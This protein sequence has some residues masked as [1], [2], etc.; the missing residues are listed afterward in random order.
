[1]GKFM[2]CLAIRRRF[3]NRV[4]K[5]CA[6]EPESRSTRHSCGL[7]SRS[8]KCTTA[9]INSAGASV[10]VNTCVYAVTSL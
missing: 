5:K 9:V 3:A 2:S 10:I 7:P 6:S 4:V 8:S 1:M